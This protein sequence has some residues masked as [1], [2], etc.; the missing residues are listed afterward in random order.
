MRG[1]GSKLVILLALGVL[2]L[3]LVLPLVVESLIAWRLQTELVR[4]AQQPDVEVSSIEVSS[5]FPPMMLLGRI[6]RVQVTMA[7]RNEPNEPNASVDLEG[8]R[9]YVPSLIAGNPSI[10]AEHCLIHN[11]IDYKD[12]TDQ[13][14]CLQVGE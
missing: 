7:Q 6:D 2:V 5:S 4:L 10:E 11:N 12:V 1:R 8:V 14:Q 3:Y 9:V 13:I